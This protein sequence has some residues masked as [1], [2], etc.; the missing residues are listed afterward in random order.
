M[1]TMT[2]SVS[3]YKYIQISVAV[4]GFK[5]EQGERERGCGLFI[6]KYKWPTCVSEVF[7]K[8]VNLS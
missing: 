8:G 3:V 5:A 1:N 2:R 7:V 6:I 4:S